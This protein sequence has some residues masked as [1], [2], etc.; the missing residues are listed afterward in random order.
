MKL[1]R[2]T[3]LNPVFLEALG[4]I[5]ALPIPV[6]DAVR[7]MKLITKIGEE[8]DIT[9]SVKDKVFVEFGVTSIGPKGI[10]YAEGADATKE[11]AFIAKFNELV[12]EEFEVEFEPMA[13]PEGTNISVRDLTVLKDFLEL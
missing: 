1:T 8:T 9:H 5:A 13:L 12:N 11:E 7:L 3:T 6:K 4:K 2:G 10:E